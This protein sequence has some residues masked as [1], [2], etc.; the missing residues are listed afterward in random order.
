MIDEEENTTSPKSSRRMLINRLQQ[1]KDKRRT[2]TRQISGHI[3]TRW[4][5]APEIILLEK[6]YGL[7]VDMWALGCVT[8]ELF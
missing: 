6:D 1:T 5:R 2:L 3:T 8:G 4:Y 7:A